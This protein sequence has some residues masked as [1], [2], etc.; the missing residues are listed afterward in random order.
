MS[1]FSFFSRNLFCVLLLGFIFFNNYSFSQT[2]KKQI[3]ELSIRIDSINNVLQMNLNQQLITLKSVENYK[4]KL[5]KIIDSLRIDI[6]QYEKKVIEDDLLNREIN[7]QILKL[8][9]EIQLQWDT[10]KALKRENEILK[11]KTSE[12][13]N[14]A[15]VDTYFE[16]EISKEKNT[17]KNGKLIILIG[18][19]VGIDNWMEIYSD[20][21]ETWSPDL[22]EIHI[23]PAN[24]NGNDTDALTCI[25]P[26]F[27]FRDTNFRRFSGSIK[28]FYDV[29][30]TKLLL[31]SY[32]HENKFQGR[33]KIYRPDRTL[34]IDHQYE[35]GILLTVHKDLAERNWSFNSKKS[36]LDLPMNSDFISFDIENNPVIQLGPTIHD[37]IDQNSL[38]EML[39]KT[40]FNRSFLLNNKIFTGTIEGFFGFSSIEKQP[41]FSLK[42]KNG[43]LHGII[44]IYGNEGGISYLILE[45]RFDHG[46]LVEN[47]YNLEK[48]GGMA[49]PVIYLYPRKQQEIQVKLSLKGTMT[50]S[51]PEY[52]S[53]GWIV[54][55]TQDGTLFDEKGQEYYALFWEGINRNQF[56]YD[57]GYVIKGSETITF[58][59]ENLSKLG[60][61]RREANEFIMYWLPQMENNTYNL[62]HFS[63]SEYES[64]VQMEINP[65]PETLI[66]IMMVWS[67]LNEMMEIPR[68][69]L[70]KLMKQRIGFTVVEW[71]GKKQLYSVINDLKK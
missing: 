39:Q 11:N 55:A 54:N 29:A 50:H 31:S 34:Y 14:T 68:Q 61:T 7:S 23:I 49:K 26:Y 27:E 12:I 67:P 53:D 25:Y 2:K 18:V 10:I 17:I 4:N 43:K 1:K 66:R 60:L 32:I 22:Q 59:E 21:H 62:V 36:N 13:S 5:E 20:K 70:T 56:T 52:P 37:K 44:K 9:S 71:G 35:N 15:S 3:E 64:E 28:V 19:C 42:L 46:T 65:S 38:Y 30:R 51:Y 47:I 58:L 16:D 48:S 24:T 69:D 8:N 41:Y 40:V 33:L 57:E 45:E 6:Y 63:T